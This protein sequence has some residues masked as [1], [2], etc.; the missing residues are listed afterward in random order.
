MKSKAEQAGQND[1]QML[2]WSTTI[3]QTR[4]VGKVPIEQPVAMSRKAAKGRA[5]RSAQDLAQQAIGVLLDRPQ[6]ICTMRWA[7]VMGR[8]MPA[9]QR[10]HRKVAI[11]ADRHE[12]IMPLLL[13][14]D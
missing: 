13:Q 4:V 11:L 8:P 2:W 1:V 5:S 12:G 14:Y 9:P 6:S 7:S 10:L 3:Q